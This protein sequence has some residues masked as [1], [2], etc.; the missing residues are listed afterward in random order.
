MKARNSL[1]VSCRDKKK[2]ED[3]EIV[4]LKFIA[5]YFLSTWKSCSWPTFDEMDFMKR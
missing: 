3:C 5:K 2:T 1:I 4:F